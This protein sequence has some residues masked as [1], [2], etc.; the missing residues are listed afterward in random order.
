MKG[1]DPKAFE[2][3]LA[4]I[5]NG[6]IF[7]NF[8]SGFLA[9][10]RGEDF[11]PAGGIKDRGIDGLEHIFHKKGLNRII[12]QSS[13][14]KNSK[15][16]ILASMQKISNNKI[17]FDQLYFVTNQVVKNQD[18]IAEKIFEQFGKPIHVR[19]LKWLSSHANENQ[20]T[21]N[22]FK[23]FIESY[24]HD[25][26]KIGRSYV[27]GDFINDP[28]LFVFLRQ[29]FDSSDANEQLD[30]ILA[31]SLILFALE[32]TDPDKKKFKTISQIIQTI[33][34]KISFDPKILHSKIQSRLKHLSTKPRKIKHHKN[35]DA[36]V[37]PYETRFE[38]Q[39]KNL[40]D[41]RLQEEFRQSSE[42]MLRQHLKNVGVN[43]QD[44]VSLM[45]TT[46]NKIYYQQGLEFANFV[47]KGDNQGA[48]EKDLSDTISKVVDESSIIGKNKELVKSALMI[49]V[50]EIVYNGN[51]EQKTFL[52]RLSNT[53]L[54]LFLLQCDPKICTF[55]SSLAG[56]LNVYVCT[57]ILIPAMSEYYL[58]PENRRHWNL[59]KGAYGCGVSLV[60]NDTIIGELVSHFQM[61]INKYQE[62]Y[63]QD[64]SIYLSNEI[65][66][67]Y[68]DEILI[69]AYFYAKM[70]GRV[71]SFDDFIENFVSPNLNNAKSELLLWLKEE[72]EIKYVSDES[73]GITINQHEQEQLLEVLKK[74]KSSLAKA[75]NDV[76][77]IL[78]IYAIR[79][80]NNETGEQDI[81]GYRT[82]WLSTDTTTM[83]AVNEVFKDKHRVSCYMRPDFL[84]NY[85]SLAPNP[86]IVRTAF[87]S[88]FPTLL[89]VN[90]SYH[91]PPQIINCV[92]NSMQ[93][94][95]TKNKGR[96]AAILNTLADRLKADPKSRNRTFVKHFLDEE[97]ASIIEK[98]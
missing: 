43:I 57:S 1:I 29:Q 13:I 66:T 61:I 78:S 68:I 58:V 51:P 31:D 8:V 76:R 47:L 87:Q 35:I 95:K 77:L 21:I 11:I 85:I 5:D 49:T 55:F 19:D 24:L 72:F 92:Q 20:G 39:Q 14:E 38:I 2:F 73:L 27:V 88:L 40:D 94:H 26:A 56:K 81:F 32:G 62:Y 25:F 30:N 17:E 75:K 42:N 60:V 33:A 59:L 96:R 82:W 67:L 86:A 36:Y 90:V 28:R 6:D 4:K 84:Y 93:E 7:E 46:F 12:Y 79:E 53:Y 80:K 48:F 89:G 83:K 37:L 71:N 69:R 97:L 63:Q 45:E 18:E 22:V 15:H 3:A 50:R 70:R 41:A 23:T 34:E 9:Q 91:L 98:E 65:Q 10:I 74:H 16:K 52:R 54:M 44:C 64:E